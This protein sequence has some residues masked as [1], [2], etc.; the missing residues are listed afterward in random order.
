ML[1]CASPS[2]TLAHETAGAARIPAFPASL[3][4][5]ARHPPFFGGDPDKTRAYG[6]A[7][8][9]RHGCSQTKAHSKTYTL[10]RLSHCI[11]K[12]ILAGEL[13]FEPRQTE[14]ESVVLPLHHSPK[15]ALQNQW[16]V[17]FARRHSVAAAGFGDKPAGLAPF[18]C[19]ARALASA[20]RWA[21]WGGK[22]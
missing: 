18:Y 17:L 7:R 10:M 11:H 9:R 13:G 22:P 21:C 19:S 5:I 1:V 2:R 3:L 12:E 4:G 20:R 14:S 15:F 16:L 6:A 8:S